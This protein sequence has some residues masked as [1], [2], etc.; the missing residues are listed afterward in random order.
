MR[1]GFWVGCLCV[2]ASAA[3]LV[4]GRIGDVKNG[5]HVTRMQEENALLA[6]VVSAEDD[7]YSLKM[8]L[9][10]LRTT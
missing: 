8:S 2:R 6:D 1:A 10:S 4:L 9:T 5:F 7:N 3:V